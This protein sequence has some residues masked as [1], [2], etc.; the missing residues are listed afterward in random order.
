VEA[1]FR[2]VSNIPGDYNRNGA[3]DAA[4]YTVWRDTLNAIGSGLAADGN[5]NQ[6]IDADDYTIWANAFAA[7]GDGAALTA[8]SAPEP[9]AAT[10]A[11]AAIAVLIAPR[12]AVRRPR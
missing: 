4:D 7:V 9:S 6:Q 3:V 1:Q 11:L 10:L 5:D 2:L 12:I 8:T